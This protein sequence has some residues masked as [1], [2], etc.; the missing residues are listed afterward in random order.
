LTM[1]VMLRRAIAQQEAE[2]ADVIN[3]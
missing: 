1:F 2:D 3:H